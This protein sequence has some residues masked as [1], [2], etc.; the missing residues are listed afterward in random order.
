MSIVAFK[1]NSEPGNF[2]HCF[3]DFTISHI[4]SK[5]LKIAVVP[6]QRLS[7]VGKKYQCTLHRG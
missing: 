2:P 5:I 6:E 1:P 7:A 3:E 4:G